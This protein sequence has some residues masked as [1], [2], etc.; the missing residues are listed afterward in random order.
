MPTPSRW[1]VA[2]AAVSVLACGGGNQPAPSPASGSPALKAAPASSGT[3]SLG[4]AGSF[5]VLAGTAVTCT[6]G[7]VVGDV[8]V[9]PGTAITLTSCPVTGTLHAGDPAAAAAQIDFFTAYDAFQAM[10]C[11]QTLTTLDGLTLAPGVY[12]FDA[13][14]TSTGGVLT[15]SGPPNGIWIFKVGTLGTGA[16]TG[17]NFSVVAPEGSTLPCG[18]VYWWAAEAVTMTDSQ[19]VGTILAGAAITLTRGTFNGDAYAKAAVTITGDAVTGCALGG[20]ATSCSGKDWVTGG[21]WIEL[22]PPV[23]SSHEARRSVAKGTFG[24]SGGIKHGA[25]WGHLTYQDH[26]PNG[27]MVKSTSVTGY[28]ALDAFTRRIDGTAKVNGQSGFTFEVDVSD[29]GEP[30]RDDTFAI[31]LSNGYTASGVLGGGNIQLHKGHGHGKSCEVRDGHH[32]RDDGDDG[33]DDDDGDGEE[34]GDRDAR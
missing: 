13:A 12:C 20:G 17:T 21:G 1:F 32:D 33:E 4:A 28:S 16:L 15:L 2:L 34:M 11:D 23:E 10:A 30:G 24:V 26:A 27:A 19:F 6:N 8:G 9:S 5:A 3:P 25:F 7:T 18:S 31:R 22:R 29:H 14:V